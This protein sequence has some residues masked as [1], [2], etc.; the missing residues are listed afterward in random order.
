M[1]HYIAVI[2]I[3]LYYCIKIESEGDLAVYTP[4]KPGDVVGPFEL[5]QRLDFLGIDRIY[6]HSASR[7]LFLNYRG[8]GIAPLSGLKELAVFNPEDNS[9]GSACYLFNG[10]CLGKKFFVGGHGE[11]WRAVSAVQGSS[12]ERASFVL[13]R[14]RV[15]NKP[16]ILR[17][18]LREIYFGEALKNESRIARY[19]QFFIS[20]DDYW[21]VFRD[22]GVSLQQL[23]YSIRYTKNNAVLEPSPVWYR[24]RA[25]RTGTKLLKGLMHEVI[26]GVAVLHD[27][28]ILHRDLKP[29]NILL[30]S[31]SGKTRILIADFSS[32]VDADSL[33]LGLYEPFGPTVSVSF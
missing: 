2:F 18:A 31:E 9:D 11:V 25:Q 14:M 8:S 15:V 26:A 23:L 6:I 27:R 33:T 21:L 20:E 28:E 7:G 1:R 3:S 13:K 16:N 4:K 24:L 30:K 12:S 10:F 32:A 22:E 17:C 19:E 29:A 5:M